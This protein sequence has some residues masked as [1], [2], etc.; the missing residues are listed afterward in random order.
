VLLRAASVS[1]S[2][3]LEGG[4]G[5]FKREKKK[6]KEG[7]GLGEFRVEETGRLAGLKK[8]R[9]WCCLGFAAGWVFFAS[10]RG[11]QDML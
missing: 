5:F 6:E 1:C 9:E 7:L 11:L 8:R 3:E 2:C 10:R 4:G